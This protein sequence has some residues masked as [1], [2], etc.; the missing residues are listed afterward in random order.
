MRVALTI[1]LLVAVAVA[2]GSPA[3]AQT[4][5]Y[6][7]GTVK[8]GGTHLPIAD[9]CVTF[10]PPTI[11]STATDANGYYRLDGFP[12]SNTSRWQIRF[13]KE[14]YQN[15]TSGEFTV[16]G[17]TRVDAFLLPGQGTCSRPDSPR[18]T[19]FLP[20]VTKTLGGPNGFVT[21]FIVQN[22]S[23]ALITSLRVEFYRFS[24]G[25][26]VTQRDLC[27][28][29]PGTS[30]AHISNNDPALP[31]DSQFSVVVRSYMTD[32]VAVVNQHQGSGDRAE[33]ASYVGA[34]SGARSVFLPNITRRFFGYVTPFIIQNLGTVPTVATA[35]F[36]SFDGTRTATVQRTIDPGRSRFV[37]PN[38]E[39]GLV[40][41]TQYAVTVTSDQ[42]VSV[43]VNTHND[44]PEVERPVFYSANGL[45][46]GAS[47]VYGPYLPKNVPGVGAGVGTVVV[48]NLGA[49]ATRP[50]LAF[51]PLGGGATV[52]FDGP[53]VAPR[54]A[55][56]FD[57]RYVNGATDRDL[58]PASPAAGCLPDGE[59]SFRASAPNGQIAAV[60][61]VIGEATA[62]GYS[63]LSGGAAQM[64]LPNVTRT[65]GGASGWTT[66]LI[67]QSAGASSA[68]ISWYRFSDGS[69]VTTQTIA[70]PPG[71]AQR[72]DPRLVA[73]L[74][75]D[76]QYSVVVRGESGNL[77]AIVHQLNFQGGDGAMIYEG[78]AR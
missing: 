51:T 16:T 31:H 55:W 70:L 6:V 36:V 39:P 77:T 28:L 34:S 25:A 24:D 64:Y 5:T 19:V 69:L 21:P 4:L 49:A 42:P 45:T 76:T 3:S 20:N 68:T 47:P 65:L 8:D 53:E 27:V 14:G 10:G 46:A 1:A 35:S 22:T 75:D 71:G 29:R 11:C 7:E 58:C 59:F 37:D 52:T 54:A 38:S 73:G 15:G 48:Q 50:T 74:S 72:V 23:N 41:G 63:A 12:I 67:V 13:S 66:P 17:P 44:A 40:D 30:F 9:V 56:A 2:P 61:N 33:A 43:V 26:L 60:V 78:F 62:A 32:A 57:P 18:T